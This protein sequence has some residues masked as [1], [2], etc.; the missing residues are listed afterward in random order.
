M[1]SILEASIGTFYVTIVIARLVALYTSEADRKESR[2]R[3]E[4]S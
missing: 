2:D 4:P 3:K 1:L